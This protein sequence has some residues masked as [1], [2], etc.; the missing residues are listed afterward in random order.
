MRLRHRSYFHLRI[1]DATVLLVLVIVPNKADVN[2]IN[3]DAGKG[4]FDRIL[5]ASCLQ[6]RKHLSAPSTGDKGA[7]QD[8]GIGT[9]PCL[10]VTTE[11]FHIRITKRSRGPLDGAPILMVPHSEANRPKIGGMIPLTQSGFVERFVEGWRPAYDLIRQMNWYWELVVTLESQAEYLPHPPFT[12]VR[13][14]SISP[15]KRTRRK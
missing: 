12:V 6:L 15:T 9:L 1:D 8:G 13:D 3:R 10:H 7:S 4:L 5:G 2:S 14:E 11:E